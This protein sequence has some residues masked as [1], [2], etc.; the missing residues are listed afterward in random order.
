MK[1]SKKRL[2]FLPNTLNKYSIRKFTVG[3]AS[4]L[5]GAT[6]FLGVSNEAEAAEKIDSPTKE[7]VATAEEPATKEEV[8]TAEEP[9]TKEEAATAEEPATKEE[10]ATAEEPATKEEVA[11][12]EEPA[13][14]EEAATAEEPATKEEAATVEEPATKEEAATAEEPATKEEAATAEEPATKEEAATAEE[15]ATKEEAATA[16]EPA[17]KEEAAT[18]EEPATKEEAATAEEPATKEEAAT[19]E[20]PATKEEAATAEESATKEEAATAEE[21]ATKEEATTAEEPHEISNKNEQSLDMNKNSTI[22]EKID[23]TKQAINELNINPKDISNIETSIKNNSDLKNLSKE[24]LNNEILRAAL[25]NESNNND[26]GL[27]TLSAIEPLTT[28]VR[29][30]N[31]SL[32]PVSKLRMLAAVTSG[33][34][35]NDKVNITNASLT[36]NKKNNQHDDNTVWPTS[37]EQLRLSADYELDNSIKEGDT[38]TIKYGDYIRPGALELPAKNTQ[39]RSKE[40][41]IVANGVYDETTNTTTYTFT[42]YVDQYQN[43]T[44]SFNLLATP[45][46]ETVTKDKQSYP[47]D[48]TI[49][50]QEVRENFVVDYG[51]HKDHLTSAAVANVDNVN[52]KHNEVVYLNQPGNRI[53][54]AKYFSTVQNGNFIPNETKVYEVLDDN[55]LVD[56]FNPN[57]NGSAVKDVTSEFTPKYSLNNTRVDIDLNR[58]NM[59]KGKR[60]IITQAV[61]PSGTG[62]V[63]TNYELTRYGNQE[64]R[65]PTGTKSTTVSYINGSSTAQGDNPTYSLGDYVWLDKNKDGIQNDDEKGIPGVYVILKDSNNKE[66][67]RA[68]TDETGHYQFNNL[69]NGTYNVEFVI[70]NN[71]TPSPSN[72]SDND[73][74]DSDGQKDG[75]NNVVVAKGIINNADNMTVDTGFYEKPTY[76]LGDYVWEDTNKDGIQDSDEK[77]IQGVTVTLKDSEGNTIGTT[78]TDEN[79]KYQFTGLENGT[80]EV[81]FTTPEGYT[82]TNANAGND[83][84]KDSDGLT[85]TGVINDADNWTLDSGFYKP[86]YNLGD[87]VWEDTNKDGIQDSDEKGIQG[88]TVTLKDSEGNTIGTT[89]TDENG[90]YQFTG[91]ENGTYEVSFT[92]PEGYTPTNANAG[93]DDT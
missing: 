13:T 22:D 42:N 25:L 50:N 51:N 53:Y 19:A 15:P 10:A 34:N 14:K 91:L 40:G 52:N 84:T 81:S 30:K 65:Y 76:N 58:S 67:Q 60:Y 62:N 82:P 39:L 24:E 72:T 74:I 17:T 9:A 18:A 85:T 47:M 44:G 23:Y 66:L 83:D 92:T 36:L 49:A 61:K 64:S 41:S 29:N 75:D 69:Q 8:A 90:K 5:V 6:L 33:Q 71:Y 89:T 78:T 7:K 2:D 56:S 37:N 86:T 54:D 48:V 26:Y 77:G 38:F 87:Y 4:I 57:L 88:V 63:T 12:A 21:S 16:E 31:N 80:Y 3:T 35:V 73:T 93:N 68:T 1:N 70:P 55:V 27:E 43:I 11:T 79:G 45:K 20:E 32:S 59:N 46:R 28:N